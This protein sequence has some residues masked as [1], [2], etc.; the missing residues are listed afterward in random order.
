MRVSKA[1]KWICGVNETGHNQMYTDISQ[2]SSDHSHKNTVQ[3][4]STS[5]KITNS[6]YW[7]MHWWGES[8]DNFSFKFSVVVVAWFRLIQF[9][10][11]NLMFMIYFD[12][13]KYFQIVSLQWYFIKRYYHYFP[14]AINYLLMDGRD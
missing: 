10:D 8:M 3:Q 9:H 1:R 14:I 5:F 11:K 2:Q 4:W 6:F 12:C 7:S 13:G